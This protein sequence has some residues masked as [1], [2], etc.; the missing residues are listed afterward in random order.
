MMPQKPSVYN[1]PE[2]TSN[3]SRDASRFTTSDSTKN[4]STTT[5]A[6]TAPKM[7]NTERQPPE[8]DEEA[9]YGGPDGRREADDEAHQ[10]HRTAVLAFWGTLTAPPPG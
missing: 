8:V 5:T 3:L 7:T 10:T 9:G 6:D 4:D 2:G 1:S